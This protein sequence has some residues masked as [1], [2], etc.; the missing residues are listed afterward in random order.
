MF[1]ATFFFDAKKALHHFQNEDL[2]TIEDS[3]DIMPAAKKICSP[4][5]IDI[6]I[7]I[8]HISL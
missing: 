3:T 5:I 4:F 6:K 1:L 8:L 2:D 7:L